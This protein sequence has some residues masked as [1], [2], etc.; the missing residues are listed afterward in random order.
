MPGR[1]K[2]SLG[3]PRKHKV[4]YVPDQADAEGLFSETCHARKVSLRIM[5]L[6]PSDWTLVVLAPAPLPGHDGGQPS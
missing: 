5:A 4:S 2:N 3:T 6:T 1:I